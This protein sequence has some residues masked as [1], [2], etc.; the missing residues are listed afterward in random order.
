MPVRTSWVMMVL[1][2][3]PFS[4]NTAAYDRFARSTEY[5]WARQNR[6]GRQP[7]HQFVGPGAETITL[8]GVIHP[9]YRGGLRMI[10]QMRAE[11]EKGEPL[12]MVDGLGF[13]L[14]RWVIRRIDETG[15]VFFADGAPRQQ[16]FRLS[17]AAYGE[18]AGTPVLP[19]ILEAVR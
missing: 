3:F 11:A 14:G 10:A 2:G 16:A 12:M 19:H 5:R 4:M 9:H 13:V 8:N 7:A 6:I 15:T 18:D 17:L 1:G